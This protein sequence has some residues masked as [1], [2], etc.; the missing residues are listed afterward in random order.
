M[1]HPRGYQSTNTL[2]QYGVNNNSNNVYGGGMHHG[3]PYPM[4]MGG[5]VDRVEQWRQGV[6]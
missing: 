3:A 5:S 4:P 6:Q 2:S 1:S